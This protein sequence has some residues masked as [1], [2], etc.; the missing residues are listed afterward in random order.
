MKKKKN[1]HKMGNNF[2]RSKSEF[3]FEISFAHING[4]CSDN[5]INVNNNNIKFAYTYIQTK[6]LF[7]GL[8]CCILLWH[9]MENAFRNLYIHG[10]WREREEKYKETALQRGRAILGTLKRGVKSA[11]LYFGNGAAYIFQWD[12]FA[13]KIS[14]L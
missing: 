11:A 13:S 14:L 1:W 9:M 6:Q 10:I 8:S 3:L 4:C 2:G 12:S 5:I 7:Y